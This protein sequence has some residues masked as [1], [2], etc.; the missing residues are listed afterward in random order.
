MTSFVPL[1]S[2]DLRDFS[3]VTSFTLLV[4]RVEAWNRVATGGQ[5]ASEVFASDP[6]AIEGR[7]QPPADD[8]GFSS[9]LFG[10]LRLASV[11]LPD[12][13]DLARCNVF[14]SLCL[15]G[16]RA[17]FLR[18]RAGASLPDLYAIGADLVGFF[19]EETELHSAVFRSADL[20]SARF[21]GACLRNATLTG[22]DLRSANLQC[23]D[24][25]GANLECAD[26]RGA[27]LDGANWEG[28]HLPGAMLS[29][30]TDHKLDVLAMLRACW[31]DRSPDNGTR[32]DMMRFDA[33]C[34]GNAIAFDR[35]KSEGSCPYSGRESTVRPLEFGE[36]SALWVDDEGEDIT[37]R[38]LRQTTAG[39]ALPTGAPNPLVLLLRLF[40]CNGVSLTIKG[41]GV[42][43]T[44]DGGIERALVLF[45]PPTSTRYRVELEQTVNVSSTRVD[46]A[47][48]YVDAEDEDEARSIVEDDVSAYVDEWDYGDTEEDDSDVESVEVSNVTEE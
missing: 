10:R 45:A 32:R 26:L 21:R 19:A 12:H 24:L 28:T 31:R 43:L 5:T 1:N 2:G 14:A 29:F 20:H 9:R 4:S 47:T 8:S 35:W 22:A 16:S 37:K 25:R 11:M 38:A 13:L 40:A 39:D 44:T 27:R 7:I 17:R 48:V 3:D 36:D 34:Y 42:D 6:S 15:D 46:H 23:T 33:G 30:D 18:F 41:E